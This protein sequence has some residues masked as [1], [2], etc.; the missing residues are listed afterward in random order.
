[1]ISQGEEFVTD[2]LHRKSPM[3]MIAVSEFDAIISHGNARILIVS[4]CTC[5]QLEGVVK[6]WLPEEIADFSPKYWPTENLHLD[7]DRVFY[8]A[9]NGGQT[10]KISLFEMLNPFGY[11]GHRL[12]PPLPSPHRS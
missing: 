3:C 1:M 2:V 10:L 11:V 8:K 4:V 9:V 5:P 12:A 6:E 7:A